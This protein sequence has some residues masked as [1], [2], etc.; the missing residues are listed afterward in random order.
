MCYRVQVLWQTSQTHKSG[1]LFPYIEGTFLPEWAGHLRVQAGP[2]KKKDSG[3]ESLNV[4]Q[5]NWFC[6]FFGT[7]QK[8]APLFSEKPVFFQKKK[9]APIRREELVFR[10]EELV[11]RV[12]PCHQKKLHPPRKK[13][14]LPKLLLER[15]KL[16]PILLWWKYTINNFFL[17]YEK[18]IQHSAKLPIYIWAPIIERSNA[19]KRF[20]RCR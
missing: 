10:R 17:I 16:K 18:M 11:F 2:Q 5:K 19:C 3:F 15:F 4:G 12:I 9:S 20:Q 7:R 1:F 13:A 6:L 14:I 8:F